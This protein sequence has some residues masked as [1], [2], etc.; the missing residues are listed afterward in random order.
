MPTPAMYL[1]KSKDTN[2][3]ADHLAIL[4][5]AVRAYGHN[6]ETAVYDDWAKSG[7]RTGLGKRTAWHELCEAIERHEHDVVFMNSLDRGGRDLEEW[8]RFVRVARDQGVKVIAEGVDYS[9]PENR[10][11]LVFEAWMAEKELER[12]KERS[13]RTKQIRTRRG[14]STVGGHSA[15][16]GQM[17]ARA[18]DVGMVTEEHPDPRRIVA[19]PN[20]DEPLEPVLAAVEETGGN[21]LQAAK[22]LNDRGIEA[23]G[24]RGW[25]PRTIARV[26]DAQGAKRRRGSG[27]PLK[28][29][30]GSPSPLSRLVECHCGTVMTP[31]RDPRNGLWLSMVCGRGHKLG[32]AAHGPY[33]AR[34]RHVLDRLR[35]ELN[36]RIEHSKKTWTHDPSAMADERAKLEEDL[37]RL[38]RAYRAGA[39]EDEEFDRESGAIRERLDEIEEQSAPVFRF[40]IRR[41]GP[42][43]RWDGT[44]E[45]VAEDLRRAVRIVRLGRDMRP[46]EVM[47]R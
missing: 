14:D 10:D 33:T 21:V 16:Y 1:R 29:G 45:E 18:G 6:S 40:T 43:V 44:D 38:G 34:S 13:A 12:A 47:R 31:T 26:V 27:R 24:R 3:K 22:L 8:L 46:A 9:R 11:R 30:Q 15:P 42:I 39:V 37:R 32:T 19:V 2:T 36:G 5:D 20:P 23:R 28:T 17:W 4:T 41:T 7:S 25:T 35:D